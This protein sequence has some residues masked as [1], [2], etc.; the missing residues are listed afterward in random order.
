M[1]IFSFF[2]YVRDL[3]LDLKDDTISILNE[4]EH[5]YQKLSPYEFG[6]QNGQE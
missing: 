4:K 6:G 3:L 1:P 2:N 5:K